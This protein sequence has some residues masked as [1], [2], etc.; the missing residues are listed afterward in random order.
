MVK[1]YDLDDECVH[2]GTKWIC[3]EQRSPY[4]RFWMTNDGAQ[5]F[6]LSKLTFDQD[7]SKWPPD[8]SMVDNMSDAKWNKAKA[9]AKAN[10]QFYKNNV[11]PG[12]GL[13]IVDALA[14]LDL[15]L[16]NV[17]WGTKYHIALQCT[18]IKKQKQVKQPEP[19][20][21]PE[22]IAEVLAW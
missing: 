19:M 13:S 18:V 1:H 9:N 2:V 12:Q 3:I 17:I 15:T 8:W 4:G 5:S 16:K 10:E 21:I 22:Y 7:Y 20:V 11:F 14:I 6:Y